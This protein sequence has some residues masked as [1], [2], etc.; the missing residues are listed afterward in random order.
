ME[1]CSLGKLKSYLLEQMSSSKKKNAAAKNSN[2]NVFFRPKYSIKGRVNKIPKSKS[3]N[4]SKIELGE[5]LELNG[6]KRLLY[7]ICKTS[8]SI[9]S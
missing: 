6:Q 5:G 7:E 3:R 8:I 9:E 4:Y 1:Q 2:A